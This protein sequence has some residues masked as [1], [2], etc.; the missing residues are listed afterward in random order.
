MIIAFAPIIGRLP[1]LSALTVAWG[2][3]LLSVR[4]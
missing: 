2:T 1:G 3:L 4:V